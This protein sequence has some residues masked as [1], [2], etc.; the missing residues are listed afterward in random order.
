MPDAGI[1][2]CGLL[3]KEDETDKRRFQEAA[4]RQ[5]IRKPHRERM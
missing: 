4:I 5:E 1:M 2:D 3:Q